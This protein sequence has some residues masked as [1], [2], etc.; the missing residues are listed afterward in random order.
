M[1][2]P[3]PEL[4][5]EQGR[6]SPPVLTQASS[7]RERPATVARQ[8]PTPDAAPAPRHSRDAP[9]RPARTHAPPNPETPISSETQLP[10]DASVRHAHTPATSPTTPTA[11]AQ[12]PQTYPTRTMRTHIMK[13]LHP[14]FQ[15]IDGHSLTSERPPAKKRNR[16]VKSGGS[17]AAVRGCGYIRR[18]PRRASRQHRWRTRDQTI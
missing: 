3:V 9:R 15:A 1:K 8:R 2:G 11:R 14:K 10:R 6:P 18:S 5:T 17:G 7:A 13:P 4:A 12:A 16:R